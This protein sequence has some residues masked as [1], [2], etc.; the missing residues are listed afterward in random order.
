MPINCL[1][2][3]LSSRAYCYT[4]LLILFA[5]GL[6]NVN[7]Q[8]VKWMKKQNEFKRSAHIKDQ[9]QFS[10]G[11]GIIKNGY[12]TEVAYGKYL[13]KDFL[14][15]TDVSYETIK[16]ESTKLNAYYVSPEINYCIE[17]LNSRFFIN[18]KG[19]FITGLEYLNNKIMVNKKLSQFVF[20]EKIGIKLEYFLTPEFSLNLDLEQRFIN[21]S[22]IGTMARNAYLSLSYNF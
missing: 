9:E 15:R 4:F 12:N 7:A 22:Q 1:A 17:K 3:H 2:K 21:N 10:L 8:S 19:G 5:V 20:G 18:V 13:R 11:G 6:A 16:I 14:F